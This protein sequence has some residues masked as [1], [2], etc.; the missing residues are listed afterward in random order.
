MNSASGRY[1]R[2]KVA[3]YEKWLGKKYG[4]GKFE[5]ENRP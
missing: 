3:V 5:L 1:Q 2:F 4:L